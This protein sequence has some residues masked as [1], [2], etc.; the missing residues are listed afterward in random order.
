[1]NASSPTIATQLGNETVT[2]SRPDYLPILDKPT[3]EHFTTPTLTFE[4]SGD[5]GVLLKQDM[6]GT[7]DGGIVVIY[8]NTDGEGYDR[9]AI[10]DSERGSRSDMLSN[11]LRV[12]SDVREHVQR[13]ES[14][15][16]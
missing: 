13:F 11:A 16:D 6:G 10:T 8:L 2:Q 14:L 7:S 4:T 3:V 15:D 5:L 9:V 12:L 1:M